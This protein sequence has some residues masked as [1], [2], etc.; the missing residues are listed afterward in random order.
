MNSYKKYYSRQKLF[1][2]FLFIS[3]ILVTKTVFLMSL[4]KILAQDIPFLSFFTCFYS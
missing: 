2:D 1:S 4:L 3:F